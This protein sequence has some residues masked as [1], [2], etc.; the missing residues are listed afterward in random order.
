MYIISFVLHNSLR[1]EYSANYPLFHISEIQCSNEKLHDLP[2]I[3]QL[4]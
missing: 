3:T 4:G 1:E 2:E